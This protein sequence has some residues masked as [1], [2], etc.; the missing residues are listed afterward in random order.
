M[1]NSGE[2]PAFEVAQSKA[3]HRENGRRITTSLPAAVDGKY[4]VRVP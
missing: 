4:A 2:L 3:K 1:I